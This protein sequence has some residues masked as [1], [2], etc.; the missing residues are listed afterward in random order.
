MSFSFLMEGIQIIYIYQDVKLVMDNK[1]DFFPPSPPS[2]VLPGD[3]GQLCPEQFPLPSCGA[4]LEFAGDC[5]V[6]PLQDFGK[7]LLLLFSL[8][9][10]Q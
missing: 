1:V 2:G 9:I 4:G 5:S 3:S 7:C 10:N 6:H 8:T